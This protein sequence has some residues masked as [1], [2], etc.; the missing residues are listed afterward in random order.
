MAKAMLHPDMIS[1]YEAVVGETEGT[2][3]YPWGLVD[4]FNGIAET[5]SYLQREDLIK[6]IGHDEGLTDE[7]R[8][9]MSQIGKWSKWTDEDKK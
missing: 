6:A 9:F 2:G 3:H 1:D 8:E 5:L 4:L 7:A